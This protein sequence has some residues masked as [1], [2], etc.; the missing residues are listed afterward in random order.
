M[1]RLQYTG[2]VP[3]QT[4]Q[5]FTGLLDSSVLSTLTD[6]EEKNRYRMRRRWKKKYGT[7]C[8]SA[9]TFANVPTIFCV[10]GNSVCFITFTFTRGQ[11]VSPPPLLPAFFSSVSHPFPLASISPAESKPTLFKIGTSTDTASCLATCPTPV[12]DPTTDPFNIFSQ[13]DTSLSSNSREQLRKTSSHMVIGLFNVQSACP[14][15]VDTYDCIT[16]K[17]LDFL[18]STKHG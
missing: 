7:A 4:G 17:S 5:T 3:R 10:R 15:A 14:K 2:S 12:C 16:E 6:C 8:Q 9:C 13:P 11:F 1:C 18:L